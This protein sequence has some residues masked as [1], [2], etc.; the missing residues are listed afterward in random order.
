MLQGCVTNANFVHQLLNNADFTRGEYDTGLIDRHMQLQTK[1]DEEKHL[2]I[3]AA[4]M[5]HLE[6]QKKS[7]TL[8]KTEQ[9]MSVWRS[10]IHE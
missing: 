4:V 10:F 6:Q 7:H 9:K 8:S 3:I 2:T 5:A 1:T